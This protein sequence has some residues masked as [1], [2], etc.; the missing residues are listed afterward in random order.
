[1][2]MNCWTKRQYKNCVASISKS[3]RDVLKNPADAHNV[4][5]EM[6]ISNCSI[7]F[8]DGGHQCLDFTDNQTRKVK[9]YWAIWVSVFAIFPLWRVFFIWLSK[10]RDFFASFASQDPVKSTVLVGTTAMSIPV[11]PTT[12]LLAK[13]TREH[14]MNKWQLKH[15]YCAFNFFATHVTKSQV[16]VTKQRTM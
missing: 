3:R 6:I 9:R 1:M 13:S 12:T 15:T 2:N 5:S 14:G 7:F 16:T 8:L 4:Y 11:I 10:M